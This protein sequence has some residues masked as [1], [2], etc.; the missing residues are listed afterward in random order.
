M[1]T[2]TTHTLL[3]K[4]T[5]HNR[6]LHHFI[7]IIS[8]F[9]SQLKMDTTARSTAHDARRN[10][11]HRPPLGPLDENKLPTVA[12]KLKMMKT[13]PRIPHPLSLNVLPFPINKWSTTSHLIK[14]IVMGYKGA[15]HFIS[16]LLL[17]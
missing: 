10:N 12:V 2:T 9:I 15:H 11:A 16:P 1:Q 7:C 17:S 8:H 14:G 4:K 5:K 3:R 6:H 13:L